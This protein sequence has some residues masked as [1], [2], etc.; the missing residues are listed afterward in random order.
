MQTYIIPWRFIITKMKLYIQGFKGKWG[1][2]PSFERKYKDI[3]SPS[4][5]DSNI[6]FQADPV[7]W[8]ET[9]KYIGNKKI[10]TN[11]LDFAD[12]GGK[13]HSAKTI[14]YTTELAKQSDFVTAISKDVI[15]KAKISYNIDADM[16]YYPSEVSEYYVKLAEKTRKEKIILVVGRLNDKGKKV[17]L[18]YNAFTK[19]ELYKYGWE[20]HL[21]GPYPPIFEIKHKGVRFLH[22]LDNKNLMEEYATAAIVIQASVGEGLGLPAIEGAL[23]SCL[24][25]VRGV[26]PMTDIFGPTGSLYFIDDSFL[27]TALE[28]AVNNYTNIKEEIKPDISHLLNWERNIAFH[29]LN[30]YLCDKFNS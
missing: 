24:T 27:I 17:E 13:P 25:I 22:F 5:E 18:I 28:L 14:E 15:Q 8:R 7:R 26:P 21:I 1:W 23:C 30:V 19:L 4:I 12:F 20:L 9:K 2:I 3:M 6:I 10:I 11:L 29:K 16:F